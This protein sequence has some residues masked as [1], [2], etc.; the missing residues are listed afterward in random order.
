VASVSNGFAIRRLNGAGNLRP[1]DSIR[2]SCTPARK[3]PNYGGSMV[4]IPRGECNAVQLRA[5]PKQPGILDAETKRQKSSFKRANARKDENLRVEWPE[6]PAGTPYLA[7]YRKRAVC[8]G[9][10]VSG[11]KLVTHHPVFEPVPSGTEFFDAETEDKIRLFVLERLRQR[12]G[13]LP[14]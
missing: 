7:P 11:H 6:I 5:Q 9:W 2:N 10:V 14:W 1:S 4:G 12:R 13:L 3:V 8:K